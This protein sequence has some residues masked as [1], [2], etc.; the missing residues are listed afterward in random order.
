M[1]NLKLRLSINTR[2][3]TTSITIPTSGPSTHHFDGHTGQVAFCDGCIIT[4]DN[5]YAL[6]GQSLDDGLVRLKRRRLL[7]LEDEGADTAVELAGKQQ[8][9]NRRLDVL[10]VILVCVERVP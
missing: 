7:C 1:F 3:E 6:P 5:I 4:F 9:D 2:Q 10:L 8:T